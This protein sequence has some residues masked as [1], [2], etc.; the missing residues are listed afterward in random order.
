MTKHGAKRK[1]KLCEVEDCTNLAQKRGLC[2]RHGAY[3]AGV[4]TVAVEVDV[5]TKM[6]LKRQLHQQ[7][8]RRGR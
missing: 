7:Q 4:E 3:T 2:K 8:S 5:V 6:D 1:Y